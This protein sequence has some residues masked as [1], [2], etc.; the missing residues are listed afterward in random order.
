MRVISSRVLAPAVEASRRSWKCSL[1]VTP[2]AFRALTQSSRK[3][4]RRSQESLRRPAEDA[5]LAGEVPMDA[6]KSRVKCA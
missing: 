5:Y 3:L 6:V 4:L 1:A 2:A